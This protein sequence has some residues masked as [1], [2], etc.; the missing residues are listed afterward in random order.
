VPAVRV[1]QVLSN[2]RL[3]VGDLW[4]GIARR[5]LACVELREANAEAH[6]VDIGIWDQ[7]IG[8]GRHGW[9]NKQLEQ[10]LCSQPPPLRVAVNEGLRLAES[11]GER[12]NR[13]LAVG[14]PGQ[15]L[16]IRKND[17]EVD[18]LEN[19]AR[20]LADVHIVLL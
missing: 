11:L 12:D 8:R 15:L 17:C 14:R 9:V 16:G 13:S 5:L 1:F 7:V 3:D 6:L 18:W 19:A 4:E 20:G 10:S 2:P